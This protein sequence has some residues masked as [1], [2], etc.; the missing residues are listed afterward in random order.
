MCCV[1]HDPQVGQLGKPP[2]DGLGPSTIVGSAAFNL[3]MILAVCVV[4]VPKGE[5]RRVKELGVFIITSLSSVLAYVWLLLVLQWNTEGVVDLPEA[6][7]TLF[8]FPFLV[9]MSYAADRNWFRKQT[10]N[11]KEAEESGT[12]QWVTGTG[13]MGARRYGSNPDLTEVVVPLQTALRNGTRGGGAGAGHVLHEPPRQ[14]RTTY[15]MHGVRMMTGGAPVIVSRQRLKSME[16]EVR[17]QAH[18]QLAKGMA[19]KMARVSSR[20]NLVSAA[21]AENVTQV[22][23][24]SPQYGVLEQDGRVVLHVERTGCIERAVSVSYET[25]NGTALAGEDYVATSGILSFVEGQVRGVCVVWWCG[26]GAE[27]MT[28]V[29]SPRLPT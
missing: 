8:L 26:G 18:E 25:S 6:L 5:T 10:D 13:G 16:A 15:R 2:S 17:L 29:P 22:S 12:G 19:D 14:N 27:R 9:C 23:F 1:R 4:S 7:A 3:L 28:A 11:V 20:A 24:S 21:V